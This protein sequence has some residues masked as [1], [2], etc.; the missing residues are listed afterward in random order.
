MSDTVFTKEELAEVEM[1]EIRR[2]IAEL[3]SHRFDLQIIQFKREVTQ[4]R[5]SVGVRLE[6]RLGMF[7]HDMQQK[8]FGVVKR[9]EDLEARLGKL[10]AYRKPVEPDVV[11]INGEEA[12]LIEEGEK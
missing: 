7:V 10:A 4:L 9:V 6:E 5:E 2:F 1:D 11:A 8:L 3:K 12:L